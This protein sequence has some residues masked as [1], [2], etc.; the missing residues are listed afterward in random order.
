MTDFYN[1]VDNQHVFPQCGSSNTNSVILH[2]VSELYHKILGKIFKKIFMTCKN[3]TSKF[4]GYW[5]AAST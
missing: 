2:L 1:S 3:N 5:H 4:W